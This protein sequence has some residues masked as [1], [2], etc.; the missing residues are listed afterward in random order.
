MF[1]CMGALQFH[2]QHDETIHY[3][4]GAERGNGSSISHAMMF[5]ALGLDYNPKR[6]FELMPNNPRVNWHGYSHDELK[7]AVQN[8]LRIT[9]N[10][11]LTVPGGEET[12]VLAMAANTAIAGGSDPLRLLARLDAQSELF[13]YILGADRAWIASIIEEGLKSG[14][15]RTWGK[16]SETGGWTSLAARLRTR[17]DENVVVSYSVTDSFPTLPER[18]RHLEDNEEGWAAQDSWY[19]IPR[20]ERWDE[21]FAELADWQRL[22]PADWATYTFTPGINAFQVGQAFNLAERAASEAKWEAEK[23]ERERE[24]ARTQGS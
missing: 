22:D 12:N 23:A 16:E 9:W 14:L 24:R 3:V 11:Q 21:G 10:A 6:I 5:D 20:A 18:L 19:D 1:L 8:F 17:D 7:R 2:F 15:M 13:V 4:S